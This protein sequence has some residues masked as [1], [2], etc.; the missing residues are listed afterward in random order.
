MGGWV[1]GHD[2]GEMAAGGP[3]VFGSLTERRASTI[4]GAEQSV[5]ARHGALP[6]R[7]LRRG[8][9]FLAEA[10]VRHCVWAF[11]YMVAIA[12]TSPSAGGVPSDLISGIV[13]G[14][15]HVVTV[16]ENA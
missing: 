6:S 10:Q 11:A 4:R 15:G 16:P 12:R 14:A 2:H 1:D 9:P 7:T 5:P 8:S 3:V 13:C